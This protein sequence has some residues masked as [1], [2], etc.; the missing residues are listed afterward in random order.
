MGLIHIHALV[1][2]AMRKP[3]RK[4]YMIFVHHKILS[5]IRE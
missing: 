1:N 5:E 3:L 2:K 4:K